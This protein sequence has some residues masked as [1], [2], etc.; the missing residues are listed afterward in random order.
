M[1]QQKFLCRNIM[2]IRRHNYVMTM[3]FYAA[4]LSKKNLKK[5]VTTFLCFVVTLIKENE[6]HD[7]CH[8]RVIRNQQ[9]L[10]PKFLLL[11]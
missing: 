8:N 1:L 3:D 7:S 2:K 11:P 6:V 5:N 4:T 9:N 10:Y